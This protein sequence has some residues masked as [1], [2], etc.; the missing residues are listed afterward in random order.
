MITVK[1]AVDAQNKPALVYDVN[2]DLYTFTFPKVAG[3]QAAG[4]PASA[5]LPLNSQPSVQPNQRQ[6]NVAG[7]Y[8]LWF[9]IAETLRPAP[10]NI[11]NLSWRDVANF[12]TAM[13]FG[14]DGASQ[15]RQV[16]PIGTACQ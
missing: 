4:W 3:E 6:V 5:Q 16:I 14:S 13:R 12:E 10:P 1:T 8:T 9:Y 15:M 11:A 2:A 7:S